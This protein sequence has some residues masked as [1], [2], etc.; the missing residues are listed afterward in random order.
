MKRTLFQS[1]GV[2]LRGIAMGAA[3][4]VPGVSGGTIAFITGIYVELIES[5]KS[6]EPSLIGLFREHASRGKTTGEKLALGTAAVWTKINGWF[7]VALFIGIGISI[8]SLAKAIT[9]LLR[10]QPIALWSFFFGLIVASTLLIAKEIDRWRPRVIVASV[11]GIALGY[12]VTIAVPAQTP[13]AIWFV[14]LS[15]MIAIC[16]MI[17][18]GISGSFILLL[19]GKYEQI[20]HAIHDRAIGTLAVFAVGCG[21]GLL[22]FSHVLSW[23]FRHYKQATVAFLCGLMVG[24]LNK[25]WPWRHV[26][27]TRIN[28]KG[29]EVPWRDASVLPSAV[30]NPQVALAIGLAIAGFLVIFALERV[31]SSKGRSAL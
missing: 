5:L 27:E 17:L 9:Y 11:A 4:V 16:A 8:L 14:L 18:P 3:D 30:E 19:M 26:L 28:S 23:L 7:L 2:T 24:S 20:M 6:I 29:E 10:E 25:V 1:L 31:A 12:G 15:G 22:T 13:D 21:L